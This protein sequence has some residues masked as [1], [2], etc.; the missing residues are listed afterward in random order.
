VTVTEE[1]F[2]L[3]MN[4]LFW[5]RCKSSVGGEYRTKDISSAKFRYFYKIS[6]GRTY[7]SY[8]RRYSSGSVD[9]LSK[10]K[11][12]IWSEWIR[13]R[14]K[15][16]FVQQKN[17]SKYSSVTTSSAAEEFRKIFFLGEIISNVRSNNRIQKPNIPISW[18][19]NLEVN[20]RVFSEV[21]YSKK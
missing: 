9:I 3:Q 7:I 6:A 14:A 8:R 18:I 17:F 20:L 12:F 16:I 5:C 13:A 2:L 1:Y 4:L 10:P 21:N 15:D 11:I 19:I